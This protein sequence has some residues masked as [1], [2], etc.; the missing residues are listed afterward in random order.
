MSNNNK[1]PQSAGLL[2]MAK[3]AGIVFVLV[4]LGG[5]AA[6]LKDFQKMDDSARADYVCTRHP[7]VAPLFEELQAVDA[8]LAETE[9]ALADGYKTHESC[10]EVPSYIPITHCKD[11]SC[12]TTTETIF[13]TICETIPVA[14]DA[15]LE[16][17][18]VKRYESRL[19]FLEK[20]HAKEYGKCRRYVLGLDAKAAFHYYKSL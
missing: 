17:E 9:T 14:I 1:N 19:S 20:K 16:K 3:A 15:D 8:A 4:L 7:Q 10:K 18:K 2:K 12:K 6:T 13:D 11:N 5:C